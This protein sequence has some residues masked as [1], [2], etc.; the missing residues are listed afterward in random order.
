[1]NYP[2][3]W[4]V[5]DERVVRAAATSLDRQQR[6]AEVRFCKRCV[7][8]NQRP[9][10]VFDDEGVCSACRFADR[11]RNGSIDWLARAEELSALL[12]DHRRGSGWDVI[13]PG[14]G[15][16]DS[17]A[18]AW[19]LRDEHQMTP[20][21]VKW[22]PFMY[23]DIGHRNWQAFIQSGFDGLVAWPSGPAH[24]K[25]ARLC[26]EYMGDP[27]QPF[28]FGQLAYPMQMAAR[29]KIPLVMFGE[30]GEAEYGGDPSANDKRCWDF[31]DWDR[32]YLKG[33][34]IAD[35]IALGRSIGV[36]SLDEV[37]RLNEFY[38]LPP[39]EKLA[40]VEFHW[41]SY[42]RR[43]H[44]QENF[45]TASEHTGFEPN[46]ERS[47]GTYSKY[48]SLDD[49]LDGM[50]YYMAYIKFGLG[51]C[52]SD[53]A[54]EIRDGDI[55]RDD[56]VALVRKYDGEFPARYHRECLD[57]LGM[58]DEQFWRV[59]ER[60]RPAHLWETDDNGPGGTW[61]LRHTVTL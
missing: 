45:Y 16:K 37:L 22:A 52:S 34:G 51:R 36:L 58:D 9:R 32:V 21:C 59:V 24:R 27:F 30:N 48:A 10:I 4:S 29:M 46:T 57:Y 19:R 23:T 12:E 60:F 54:H 6:P 5:D 1:M 38:T 61:R 40:G 42:Y 7:I 13:V 35:I 14:S 11:K 20:L 53:A 25:L 44:P 50:H 28:V 3:L 43:W 15:G 56:G 49:K 2:P 39:R 18:V 31:D 41:F 33:S 17:A 47:E 26:F 55:T 8:S